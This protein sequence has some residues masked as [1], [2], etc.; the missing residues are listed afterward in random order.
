MRALGD[1]P[2]MDT[3]AQRN[4]ASELIEQRRNLKSDVSLE[5]ERVEVSKLIQKEIWKHCYPRTVARSDKVKVLRA[6]NK[7]FPS[8]CLTLALACRLQKALI[9]GR[10]I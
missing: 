2:P 7:I 5:S 9:R 4:I 10:L 6:T 8:L 1:R 3:K